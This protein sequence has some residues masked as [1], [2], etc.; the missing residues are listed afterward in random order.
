MRG[1]VTLSAGL[2]L[3]FLLTLVRVAGV[4]V[5]VPFPGGRRG[6]EMARIVFSVALTMALY[7]RW[8]HADPGSITGGQLAGWLVSESALGMAI[9]LA[10]SVATEAL[11]MGAQILGLQAGYGYASML[12]PNTEAESGVL[13]VLAQSLAGLLFF[14]IGLDRQVL[15][16]FAAS[17]ETIPPG[18]FLISQSLA[19]SIIKLLGTVFSVGLRLVLPVVALLAMVDI[20]IGLLGRLNA[21]IQLLTLMFPAKILTALGVLA[22]VLA[23]FPQVFTQTSESALILVKS[24]TGR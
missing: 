14:G 2:A 3:G 4:F 7:P 22:T 12:D 21:Q 13:L 16:A 23:L 6:T 5:F 19:D 11:L 24:I 17:L 9:G 15:L 1:D 8:P 20:A 18:G 10:V